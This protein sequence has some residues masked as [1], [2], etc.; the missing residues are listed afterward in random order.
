VELLEDPNP[1]VRRLAADG[2]GRHSPAG[3]KA[4]HEALV[5]ALGDQDPA[6]RRA[7]V[8]AM[9][10]IAAANAE[11][12]L[13]N[14]FQFDEGKDA[15]L[16]EGI[17]R[18]IEHLGKPGMDKLLALADSGMDK[19]LERVVEA[20]LSFRTRA[21]REALPV[22][23]KNVHL[24]DEQKADLRRSASNHDDEEPKELKRTR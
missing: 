15:Y 22:L 4:A 1:D 7:I 8:L 10:K 11:D 24:T 19:D 16:S 6:A 21:A 13:V 5:H 18:A 2:L 20:F 14:A 3:Y 17:V 23:L 9:G 12:P